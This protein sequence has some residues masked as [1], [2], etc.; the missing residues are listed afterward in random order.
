MKT[1][2]EVGPLVAHAIRVEPNTCR[3]GR[4]VSGANAPDERPGRAAPYRYD[5]SALI[6]PDARDRSYFTMTLPTMCST[7]W[8]LQM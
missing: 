7:V 2:Y 3:L 4:H 1:T 8:K 5:H 6:A